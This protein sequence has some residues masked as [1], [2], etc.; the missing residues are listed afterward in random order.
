[1]AVGLRSGSIIE[2]DLESNETSTLMESHNDG[3]AWGLAVNDSHVFSSGDD[4]Q[5]KQWDPMER[6][7]VATAIVNEKS[8]KAKKNKASTLGRHPESQ[9]ARAVAVGANGHLAVGANDGSVTI[10]DIS[11]FTTTI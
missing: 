3:E 8:R 10:R 1:M 4:N 7:C 2:Y 11:D 6:R 5:V 9:S